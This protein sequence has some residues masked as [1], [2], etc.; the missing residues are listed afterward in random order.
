M[1]NILINLFKLTELNEF[2]NLIKAQVGKYRASPAYPGYTGLGAKP[3]TQ[4]STLH[5]NAVKTRNAK[6]SKGMGLDAQRNPLAW[7][8]NKPCFTCGELGH[9]FHC[10]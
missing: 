2:E 4:L 8:V 6:L 3:P 5:E 1:G 9:T 10:C 7:V